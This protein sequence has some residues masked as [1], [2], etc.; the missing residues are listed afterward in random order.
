[1]I[2]VAASNEPTMFLLLTHDDINTIRDGKRTKFVD[3]RMTGGYSFNKVVISLHKTQ[4][5][6]EECIRSAGHKLP[7]GS[8]TPPGPIPREETCKGCSGL[9][10][11]GS[12]LEGKC[13]AC[14]S[15]SCKHYELLCKDQWK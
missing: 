2:F 10:P 9:F 11:L 14:W 3:A 5:D 4:N 12:T 13:I 15:E 7:D 6:A 8:L 1:M